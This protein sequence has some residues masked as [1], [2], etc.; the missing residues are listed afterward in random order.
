MRA[1]VSTS[2]VSTTALAADTEQSEP[3][4][5]DVVGGSGRAYRFNRLRAGF[6]LS[7]VGGT[8]LLAR[9]QHGRLEL[10]YIATAES[11]LREAGQEWP[12]AAERFDANQLF[13][14]LNV[15]GRSRDSEFA[16]ILAAQPLATEWA[17][18]PPQRA[19]A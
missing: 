7:P 10:V 5:I 6:P 4:H 2:P 3:D 1:P 19:A 18:A 16:D 8:Y 14:R 9:H 17:A 13:S 15:S 12:L 11:L